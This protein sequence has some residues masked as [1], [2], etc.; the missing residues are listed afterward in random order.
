[1]P[2]LDG[3]KIVAGATALTVGA[4]ALGQI[5]LPFIADRDKV[6]GMFEEADVPEEARRE[7]EEFMRAQQRAQEEH[8]TTTGRN[9]AGSMWSNMNKGNNEK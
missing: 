5:Y 8:P 4:V 1:M 3:R 7:M 2:R 9:M 6:R